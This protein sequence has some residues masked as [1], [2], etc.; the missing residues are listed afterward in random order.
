MYLFYSKLLMT[1]TG[2][3]STVTKKVTRNLPPALE[4]LCP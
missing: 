1:A 2:D 3:V 4:H